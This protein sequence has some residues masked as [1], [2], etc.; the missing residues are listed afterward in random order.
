[1]NWTE[2][3]HMGGYAFEVWLSW[4]LTAAILLWFVVSPKLKHR[5]ILKSVHRQEVRERRLNKQA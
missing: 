1:M 5:Q 2:F 3:F 4:G